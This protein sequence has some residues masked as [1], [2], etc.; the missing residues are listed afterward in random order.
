M[1]SNSVCCCF[2]FLNNNI[3]PF[4]FFLPTL[5]LQSICSGAFPALRILHLDEI[6]LTS[7]VAARIVDGLA[8]GC[9]GLE[10]LV[11]GEC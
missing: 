10:V 1:R 6:A 5:F 8:K 2:K 7:Q 3:L 9:E 11:L 4:L